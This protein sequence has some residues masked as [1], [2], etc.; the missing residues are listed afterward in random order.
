MGIFLYFGLSDSS[1]GLAYEIGLG[2]GYFVNFMKSFLEAKKQGSCNPR[3]YHC[4]L[5]EDISLWYV[6]EGN[7]SN[8]ANLVFS[9]A[10]NFLCGL[11]ICQSHDVF[12]SALHPIIVLYYMIHGYFKI[13]FILR[14][15]IHYLTFILCKIRALVKHYNI[16]LKPF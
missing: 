4:K 5:K 11:I 6:D 10:R 1:I 7:S 9:L 14:Y 15:C 16:C 3:F 13:V 8:H 12:A 2:Q